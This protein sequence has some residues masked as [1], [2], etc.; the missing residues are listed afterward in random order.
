MA[1]EFMKSKIDALKAST[2]Q[3]NI[4]KR[5][6]SSPTMYSGND[7]TESLV[8]GL[9]AKV[10][11][12][13]GDVKR[14]QESYVARE[15]K[16]HEKINLLEQELAAVKKGKREIIGGDTRMKI[17]KEMHSQIM[18]NVTNVHFDILLERL[19]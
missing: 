12:L 19:L 5:K 11:L 10:Q 3:K 1:Q 9:Q 8:S 6:P 13:E 7:D 18:K 14:R 16:D 2:S 15:R 4:S 17:V